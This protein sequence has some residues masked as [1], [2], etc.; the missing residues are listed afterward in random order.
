MNKNDGSKTLSV[1]KIQNL[2]GSY[3]VCVPVI[4]A[5]LIGVDK[6]DEVDWIVHKNGDFT[7]RKSGGER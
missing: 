3:Y 2:G 4:I 6:G 1:A 5:R 7:I